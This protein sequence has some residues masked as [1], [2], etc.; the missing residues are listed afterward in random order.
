[1]GGT[2]SFRIQHPPTELAATRQRAKRREAGPTRR[3]RRR[4]LRSYTAT[5][6]TPR[7]HWAHGMHVWRPYG[8]G[9]SMD[10]KAP[11]YTRPNNGH[12]S[13]GITEPRKGAQVVHKRS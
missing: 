2:W 3:R 10:K 1:M 8:L 4:Y 13:M 6:K 11:R 7:V 12:M 9:W 5:H